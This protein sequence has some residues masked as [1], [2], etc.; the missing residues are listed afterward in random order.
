[1]GRSQINKDPIISI[2]QIRV[3][4]LH[5]YIHLGYEHVHILAILSLPCSILLRWSAKKPSLKRKT[6]C[7]RKK[8]N[9]ENR[10]KKQNKVERRHWLYT[11][12]SHNHS[13]DCYSFSKDCFVTTS[14]SIH[15]E[16][17]NNPF[18]RAIL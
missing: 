1:M 4:T 9:K 10:T 16:R 8:K 14:N 12:V 17:N 18:N 7:A 15:G 6:A 2:Y 5:L 3:Y 11:M 13:Q